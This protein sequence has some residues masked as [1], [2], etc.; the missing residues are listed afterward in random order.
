MNLEYHQDLAS[1]MVIFGGTGDLTFRKL[2]PAICNLQCTHLL[3]ENFAVVAVGRRDLTVEAY[4]EQVYA[5]IQKFSAHKV[6]SEVWDIL[7][8]KIYYLKSDFDN[9]EGYGQLKQFLDVVDQ[10][11]GTRGNRVYYLAVNPEYFETIVDKLDSYGMVHNTDSWQRVVIEKPFGRDL[12]SARNLNKKITAVFREENIYR[13]DHYLG[14]E[15]IQNINVVRFA[16]SLFEPV[17]NG[18]YIDNIQI[19]SS[20]TVGVENRGGY[21]E[22]SGAL[23]DMVQNHM[24][25]LLTLTAMEPPASLDPQ[26]I[27]DEKVKVLRSLEVFTPELVEKSVVRGQYGP[28][29]IDNRQVVGYREEDRVSPTSQTETFL[30]LKVHV[31]NFRWGDVPFYIRT[32][33]RMKEKS[34]D[35]IVQFKKLPHVLYFKEQ[36]TLEPN[37]LI[38]RIQPNEGIYMQFNAKQPGIGNQIIPV[39]MDFC[40]NCASCQVVGNSPEAYEKLLL[41]VMKGDS[42]LF[43]RWD[44]VEYSWRF[45]DQISQVWSEQDTNFPNYEAGSWG[46]AAADELLQ[47]DNRHWWNI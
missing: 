32:G 37:I 41:D 4:R 29:M 7:S 35:I 34:I 17:W 12:Q 46:P 13:I 23:R 43:T 1:T 3:P 26:S 10:K 42:T 25:Q 31:R 22:H 24:L 30:A 2:M 38:I 5:G 9:D 19:S 28:G 6:T 14:K 8:R 33:K 47:Q 16:N 15:M 18:Q 11:H 20:E 36:G 39:R 45:V 21:Y 27:H 40:Q 44:E